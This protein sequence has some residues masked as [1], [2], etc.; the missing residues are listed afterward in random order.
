M[1]LLILE[2]KAKNGIIRISKEHLKNI[3]SDAKIVLVVEQKE[4]FETQEKLK[5]GKL[6][7]TIRIKT[8]NIKFNRDE[9]I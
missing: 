4:S 9:R 8:K 5:K 3:T 7:S 6:L 1:A 2:T